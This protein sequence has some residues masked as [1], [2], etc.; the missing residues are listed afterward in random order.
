L[1]RLAAIVVLSL[2][3]GSERPENALGLPRQ[4]EYLRAYLL[5]PGAFGLQ[6]R[7]T[8]IRAADFLTLLV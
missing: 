8:T 2:A 5:S 4:Y 6:H 1:A 7:K 3:P